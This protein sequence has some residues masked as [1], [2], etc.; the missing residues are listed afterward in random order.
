M[1]TDL[2]MMGAQGMPPQAMSDAQAP[3]MDEMAREIQTKVE[4]R[5]RR[6]QSLFDRMDKDF[7]RWTLKRWQPKDGE[8]VAPEDAYTTNRPRTLAQKIIAFVTGTELIIRVPNDEATE[9]QED[10]NDQ[11]E[12]LSIGFLKAA[13]DRLARSGKPS[14]KGHLAWYTVNRGAYA[15]V[16]ALLRKNEYG[17]FVDI[18][19]LDPRY[20]VVEWG[21]DEPAWAAYKM[22]RTRAWL[23]REFPETEWE[24]PAG[25]ADGEQQPE[26]IYEYFVKQKNPYYDPIS[27]DPFMACPYVYMAGTLANN[28]FIKPLHNV[29]S[30]KFPVV[31]VPIDEMPMVMTSETGETTIETFGESIY[32]ENRLQWDTLSRIGSYLTDLTAKA[33]DPPQDIFSADGTKTLDEG[34]NEKGSQ[35]ALSTLNQEEVKLRQ[36][37]DINNAV[38]ALMALITQDEVAGGLPPQ[39]FGLLDKPLS[40]V[41]LRQ[42]GNNIEHRVLPRMKAIATCVQIALSNLL[43]Q[44]ETG[45][46]GEIK[47]SGQQ[48]TSK[49][50]AAKAIP[51]EVVMGHDPLEVTMQLALPEDLST[52]WSIAGMA[53]NPTAAGEPL[54]SLEW[55]RE[56]IL[57]M[58]SHKVI[59]DQNLEILTRAQDPLLQVMEQYKMAVKEGDQEMASALYD[60]LRIAALQRQVEG[61][62]LLAQLTQM[63]MGLGVAPGAPGQ[64]QQGNPAQQGKPNRQAMNPANGAVGV[65]EK[66]GMGNQPSPDA[67]YM[68]TASRNGASQSPFG[69]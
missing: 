52:I 15:A 23:R 18:M 29:Y 66:R 60:K 3:D 61:S 46:F 37:A 13:D 25:N 54:A 42:L 33:S 7:D 48:L 43:E 22:S 28:K 17:S 58:P 57:R 31:A 21:E 30:K 40:A 9:P 55:V 6:D 44:Y 39:A 49:R 59:H 65:A 51:P 47:V 41:A 1:T 63:A 53:M 32:A 56:H 45:G 64:P 27:F 34:A 24:W 14:V 10:V 11:A 16:R 8:S 67:G 62:M 36:T 19:P 35:T 68:T 50:F 4:A 20:L 5:F 12:Q 69:V 2:S 26:P 38:N